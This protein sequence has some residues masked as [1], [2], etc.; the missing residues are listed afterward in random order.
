[1]CGDVTLPLV[2]PSKYLLTSLS[3]LHRVL[4]IHNIMWPICHNNKG[5]PMQLLLIL[6]RWS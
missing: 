4:D 3:F 2:S 5:L 1:M 6:N